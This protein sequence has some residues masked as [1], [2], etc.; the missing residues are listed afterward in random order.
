[1]T[2]NLK[3]KIR[4]LLYQFCSDIEL[5]EMFDNWSIEDWE[6][7]LMTDAGGRTFE[8]FLARAGKTEEENQ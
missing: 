8:K 4:D 1:M 6:E 3:N 7:V 2:K 5:D